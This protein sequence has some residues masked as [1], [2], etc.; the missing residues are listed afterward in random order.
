MKVPP[1]A[2][3]E[4]IWYNAWLPRTSRQVAIFP[5]WLHVYVRYQCLPPHPTIN[6]ISDGTICPTPAVICSHFRVHTL[7]MLVLEYV[8]GNEQLELVNSADTRS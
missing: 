4:L 5:P 6:L 8:A 3:Q 2:T 7:H 1:L